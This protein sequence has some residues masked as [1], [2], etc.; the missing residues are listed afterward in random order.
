MQKTSAMTTI[1]DLVLGP[2]IAARACGSCVA[3]CKVLNID[4]PDMIKPAD[5]MCMHCTG[6]GCAIYESRPGVC[7]SWDCVWRRIDTMPMETRPDRLGVLFTID[8]QAEPQTPFDRL[9]FVARAVDGREA[10]TKQG[11]MDAA[12]MLAHGP[13]PI[14]ASWD[15]GRQLIYP[16]AELAAAILDPD[17]RHPAHLVAE[18][19]AFMEKFEPFA[20]LADE[21]SRNGDR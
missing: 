19:R 8:R 6:Q 4:E 1:H 14:F 2:A 15:E 21:V 13:L 17:G 20:R 16:R 11:A 3:C 7:R 9:Y 12:A 5:Q 10:F 18:G